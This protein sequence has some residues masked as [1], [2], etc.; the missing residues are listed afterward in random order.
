MVEVMHIRVCFKLLLL[1][2]VCFKLLCLM[3]ACFNL[4][5]LMVEAM[6]SYVVQPHKKCYLFGGMTQV[7]LKREGLLLQPW[8]W[9]MDAYY[10]LSGYTPLCCHLLVLYPARISSS[11]PFENGKFLLSSKIL[12]LVVP[13]SLYKGLWITL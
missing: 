8:I 11:T 12:K 13:K 1:I 5:C 6:L 10:S 4:L 2:V 3:V 7:L 9:K